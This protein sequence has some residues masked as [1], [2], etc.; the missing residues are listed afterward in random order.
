MNK[1][2][3]LTTAEFVH[4]VEQEA[5]KLAAARGRAKSWAGPYYVAAAD[6]EM[7]HVI[8]KAGL[9]LTPFFEQGEHP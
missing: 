2:E 4:R 6:R 3:A 7:A 9:R 5:Q 8:V 1:E